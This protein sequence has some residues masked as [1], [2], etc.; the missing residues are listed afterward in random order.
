MDKRLDC[1][2]GITLSIAR[3]T[4]RINS[5]LTSIPFYMLPFYPVPIWVK[6]R[7]DMPRA[8]FLWSG[9]KKKRKY[10]LVGWPQVCLPKDQGGLGILNLEVMNNW[11]LPCYPNGYGNCLMMRVLGNTFWPKSTYPPDLRPSDFNTL[12]LPFLARSDGDKQTVSG[13]LRD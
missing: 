3:R 5:S 10:H 12:R 11:T 4:I 8:R 1:Y 7:I 2:Q 13:V 9:D 6:E